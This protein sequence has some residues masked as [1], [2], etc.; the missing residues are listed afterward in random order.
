MNV[1]G[2]FDAFSS[3]NTIATFTT[4]WN[5]DLALIADR[6]N[7]T[8]LPRSILGSFQHSKKENP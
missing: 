8:L 2:D 7:Q 6:M 5:P 4:Q 1:D 3:S